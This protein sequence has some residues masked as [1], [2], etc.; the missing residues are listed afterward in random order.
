MSAARSTEP[1]HS[2][3]AYELV[4]RATAILRGYEFVEPQK[5]LPLLELAIE[6]DPT[7]AAAHAGLAL[8][9]FMVD[10]Y[11]TINPDELEK[12]LGVA[13]HAAGLSPGLAA[14]PRVMSM[15]RLYLRQHA[16]AENDLQRALALNSGEAD[17]VEQ[18][19]YLLTM[20]GRA[21][22]A[23]AWMDRAIKLNPIFPPWYQFNR[24]L[25]LYGLG[26]YQA[27]ADAIAA[28]A[29]P[30]PLA[31]A[32]L[33]ACY[34]QMGDK[35]ASKRLI[36]KVFAA[37]PDYPFV[38]IARTQIPYEHAADAEHLVEGFSPGARAAGR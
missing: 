9:R 11:S 35:D 3:A 34:A 23:L 16:A 13:T 15:V 25:A 8:C 10:R 19:G 28:A 2:L 21:L 30:P 32:R 7:F 17:S 6:K 5:A 24:A 27:A 18:M 12:V 31:R 14:A 22:E 29:A 1:T 37:H 26:E 33:A 38:W 36:D 20:R 4:S